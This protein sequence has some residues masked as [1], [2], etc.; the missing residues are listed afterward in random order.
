VF[1]LKLQELILEHAA[2]EGTLGII[3]ALRRNLR[4]YVE[5]EP[6]MKRADDWKPPTPRTVDDE[7][8]QRD[9]AELA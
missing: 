9:L 4:S 8:D 1:E 3:A 2:E 7:I 5:Q 6:R